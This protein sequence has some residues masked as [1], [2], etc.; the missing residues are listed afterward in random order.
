MRPIPRDIS[1]ELVLVDPELAEWARSRLPEPGWPGR[2]ASTTLGDDG[3]LA[4]RAAPA[5]VRAPQWRDGWGLTLVLTVVAVSLTLNGFWLAQL[6]GS[7]TDSAGAQ[8]P[9]RFTSTSLVSAPPLSYA[10]ATVVVPSS[11]KSPPPSVAHARKTPAHALKHRATTHSRTT[12]VSA[13][14]RSR[15]HATQSVASRSASHRSKKSALVS[16]ART[17]HWNRVAGATYYDV[18]L[19]RDGARV[20]DLWPNSPTISLPTMPVNHGSKG[21]LAPGRYLWFVYPGFGAK[22]ARHYGALASSGVLVI[23]HQGGK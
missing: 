21:R 19:W 13:A 10:T 2:R 5:E 7:G 15:H 3:L 6:L 9:P 14:N 11:S 16:A 18:V 12:K 4:Q 20:L 1:P 17:L 8:D 22:S 23:Q